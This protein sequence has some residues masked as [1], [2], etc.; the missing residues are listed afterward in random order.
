MKK[1]IVHIISNLTI[2]G[3]QVLLFDIL[4]QLKNY[5]VDI[6]VI[7]IDSGYYVKKFEEIG[8]KVTNLETKGLINPSIFFKLRKA[9]KK[10]QPDIVHTHLLKADFYGRLVAKWLKVPII[11]STCHNDTTTHKIKKSERKNIYD[12]ID[13]W[14]MDYTNSYIIAISEHVKQYLIKRKSNIRTEKIFLVYNGIDVKKEEYILNDEGIKYFRNSIHLSEENFIISIVGRLEEQKGHLKFLSTAS[15]LIKKYD[16]KIL[17]LGDGA[18]RKKIE[19]LIVSEKL[20]RNVYLL[21]FIKQTDKY[22]EISNMVAVPSIWEGFGLVACEGMIKRKIVLASKVS[23]LPEVIDDGKNGFL[24]NINDE[25]DLLTKLNYII[26]NFY[27]LESI[28]FNAVKKVKEKFDI[29][30]TA[31]GYFNCYRNVIN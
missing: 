12:Y 17:L 1:K 10:I 11:F 14:V 25:N 3:G 26:S 7:T 5:D 9:L 18:E 24:Y 29:K 28:G 22:Y 4:S 31:E 6:S 16:L 15:E 30:K 13:N 2:G 21:G 19:N 27:N 20:E 8:I 23:G